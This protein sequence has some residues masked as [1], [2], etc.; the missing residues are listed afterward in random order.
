MQTRNQR[1]LGAE[2]KTNLPANKARQIIKYDNGN[3][4]LKTKS[5]KIGSATVIKCEV[6]PDSATLEEYE[7]CVASVKNEV[8]S[9][10]ENWLQQL[11]NVR[12]MRSEKPAPVDTL[13]CHQCAD[14][15]ADEKVRNMRIF[16]ELIA[17]LI[18]FL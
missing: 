9:P 11:E 16:V 10:N 5:I 18:N 6:V 2:V 13:G 15:N 8:E 3:N 14:K 4:N 1:Q 7:V 12:L 17:Y